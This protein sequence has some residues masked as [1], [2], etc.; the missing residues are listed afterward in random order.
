[1]RR[2]RFSAGAATVL[3]A[4]SLLVGAAA[5]PAVASEGQS[6]SSARQAVPA[7]F[8]T[9]TQRKV[10][11]KSKTTNYVDKSRQIARCTIATAGL[12]CSINRTASA[13]RTVN[14]GLGMSR[15]AISA[16]LGFSSATSVSVGVTCSSGPMKKGQS[17]VAYSVGSRHKYKVNKIVAR[18]GVVL[19]NETTGWLYAFNPYSAGISCQVV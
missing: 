9:I 8:G 5:A 19:S 12:S 18:S 13:T 3:L 15:D 2:L 11:N 14:V 10:V 7:G 16:Q 1:M 17:L 4:S 6:I